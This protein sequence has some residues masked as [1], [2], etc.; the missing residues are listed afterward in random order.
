[1]VGCKPAELL[2]AAKGGAPQTRHI[3]FGDP[4]NGRRGRGASGGATKKVKAGK[5]TIR[6]STKRAAKKGKATKSAKAGR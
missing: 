6:K 2:K 4:G 3:A 5:P 1:M